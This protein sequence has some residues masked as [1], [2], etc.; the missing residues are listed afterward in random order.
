MDPK[1]IADAGKKL[2]MHI[3]AA[4]PSYLKADDVPSEVLDK[5]RAILRS[6]V[7]HSPYCYIK[8]DHRFCHYINSNLPSFYC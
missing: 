3:V 5:E 6:Q 1:V 8:E 4:K 7:S 2:A